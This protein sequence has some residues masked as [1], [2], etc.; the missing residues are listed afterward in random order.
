MEIPYVVTEFNEEVGH[1][2]KIANCRFCDQVQL[3]DN[4]KVLVH[5]T[6]LSGSPHPIRVN[7]NACLSCPE[8]RT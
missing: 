3:D 1:L 7:I 8:S 4:G 2:C 6:K 5:C